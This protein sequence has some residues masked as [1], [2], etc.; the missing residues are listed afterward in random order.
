MMERLTRRLHEIGVVH[1]G[2]FKLSSGNISDYYIDLRE[3][4]GYPDTRKMI[5]EELW[6]LMDKD[7]TCVAAMG[8]GGISPATILAHDHNLNL[9]LV[10]RKPKDYSRMTSV[11]GYIPN[12]NDR[13][14]VIDDII[15]TG[16]SLQRI[17]TELEPTRAKIVGCYVVVKRGEADLKYPVRWLLTTEQLL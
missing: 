5:V 17:I 12:E 14:A 16:G 9:T 2:K 6:K 15:T 7:V 3:A 11:D 4:Y 10:R 13:I 1:K 8:Y